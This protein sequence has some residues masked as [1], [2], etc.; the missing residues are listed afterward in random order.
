MSTSKETITIFDK[1]GF[2]R[3]I[4]LEYKPHFGFTTAFYRDSI[5]AQVQLNKIHEPIGDDD[6]EW[7]QYEELFSEWKDEIKSNIIPMCQTH[8]Y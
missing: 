7:E 4:V 3:E 2:R 1:Q 6:Y 5:I 8:L